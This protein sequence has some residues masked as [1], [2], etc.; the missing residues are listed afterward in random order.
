MDNRSSSRTDR[1]LVAVHD[2][3]IRCEKCE[4]HIVQLWVEVGAVIKLV[5]EG[6]ARVGEVLAQVETC[7]RQ[8]FADLE[9]QTEGLCEVAEVYRRSAAASH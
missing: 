9:A 2:L 3:D 4:R 5:R 1:A 7:N 6:L 8:M